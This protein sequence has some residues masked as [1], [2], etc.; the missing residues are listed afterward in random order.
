[1]RKQKC[2]LRQTL[3]IIV[4]AGMIISG[5]NFAVLPVYAEEP[6]SITEEVIAVVQ[7]LPSEDEIRSL[8][9]EKLKPI[10]IQ[11]QKALELC[12]E[13]NVELLSED[14]QSKFET[15]KSTLEKLEAYLM[16]LTESSEKENED[17]AGGSYQKENGNLE[18]FAVSTD[19]SVVDTVYDRL[20]ETIK[21]IAAG[22]QTSTEVDVFDLIKTSSALE[23]FKAGLNEI[24]AAKDTIYASLLSECQNELFWHDKTVGYKF[25]APYKYTDTEVISGAATFSFAVSK[26]YQKD[27]SQYEVDDQKIKSAND[28]LSKA[29]QIVNENADKSDY[30]KLIAYKNAIC[31][32]VSYD[33][34]A[35]QDGYTGS[36]EPFQMISVFDGDPNTNVVCEGYSKAFQYLC[37]LSTFKNAKCYTVTGTMA[38]GTGAGPH[39]WNIV[40]IG[41]SNYLVD[42][43][44]CDEGSVG[45]PDLLFMAIPSSGDWNASYT[46]A[47][48]HDITYTYE[49]STKNLYGESV[50]KLASEAYDP[51]KEPADDT[52]DDKPGTSTPADKPSS[53]KPTN[54]PGSSKPTNKPSSK[55]GS[56]SSNN[57]ST[58]TTSNEQTGENNAVTNWSVATTNPSDQNTYRLDVSSTI[59]VPAELLNNE[60]L[61]TAQKIESLLKNNISAKGISNENIRVYDVVLQV[62]INGVWQNVT[63]ENFPAEGVTITVPYPSGTDSTYDFVAN[64]L[65]TKSMNGYPAGH[66]ESFPENGEI[67]KTDA[68][69]SFTVHGLSPVSIGW[70]KA[71][72]TAGSTPVNVSPQTGDHSPIMLYMV[73]MI[74]A[75]AVIGTIY[76]R[77]IH[78]ERR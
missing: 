51:S 76:V 22:E 28:T 74:L 17:G 63:A 36:K 42:V 44:N 72:G 75:A 46:F 64:H 58:G 40:S 24:T 39:M 19:S 59:E 69:I 2:R 20:V 9:P 10:Q 34:A 11:I 53:S 66:V 31:E 23:E 1:M 49:D 30:E 70:S 32:L 41:S 12:K 33:T 21:K 4:A 25:E 77:R 13:V 38:G 16:E 3:G 18:T 29:Q 62:A 50:L 55:P 8:S 6:T 5:I 45:A 47:A 15:A 7:D 26:D 35:A 48:A 37:D 56:N 68:G 78:M 73:L 60:N 65:F 61:N 52:T 27:D 14:D 43:T 54:K 67:R 57:N 71:S